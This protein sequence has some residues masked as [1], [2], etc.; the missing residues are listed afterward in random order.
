[1][2]VAYELEAGAPQPLGADCSSRGVN[3]AVYSANAERVELC[4]FAAGGTREIARLALPQRTGDIWHGFLAAPHGVAGLLYGYRVHGPYAPSLG[5]RFN[6]AKL[7]IDPCALAL[8]GDLTWHPA[9]KGAVTNQDGEPDSADSAPFIPKSRVTDT[10]FDWGRVPTPHVPWR[11]TIAYELHVKGYTQRHPGVRPELRGKYLGLAEPAVTDHLRNLGIT[12]VELMPC[13]AFVS[14]QQ[15]LQRGL[16]NFWGYNPIA[17][18]APDARYAVRDAVVEFK[19]MVR[20]LHAAGLEVVLDVVFNHT[21]E[22]DHRGPTLSWRGFDNASYY[23]LEARDRG[24]YKDF[25]GT[26]NTISFDDANVRGL[27][28]DC[29]RYWVSEMRVDGFRFDLA[30]VLG[31]DSSGFSSQSPFFAALRSDPVLAHV[32]LIAEPWDVGPGGYQLGHFPVGWSEWNDRY[33]DTVRAFWRGD[34]PLLGS[35]A[36]RL[37]GSSDLFRHHARKPTASV[38]FVAAH[39]GFT[40]HDTVAYNEKHNEAN[41]EGNQDGHSHNLSWNH[42]IEGPTDDPVIRE[43]RARQMRNMLA[44]LLLS[45]GVPMILGGDEFARTQ[46]G[47]NNAYCQD[48]DVSWV[49]WTLADLHP[50]QI[51]FVSQLC[52]LRRSRLWLRRDTFLKGSTRAGAAKDV[53]WLHPAGREMDAADWNDAGQRCIGVHLGAATVARDS[54]GH[55]V[56][57]LFNAND[58]PVEFVVPAAARELAWHVL[59]DSAHP[60]PPALETRIVPCGS[61]INVDARSVLLLE[62]HTVVVPVAPGSAPATAEGHHDGG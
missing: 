51:E 16:V 36:E 32:K 18:F 61:T 41:L 9:I 27:V 15:L 21:A 4:L 60:G 59:L 33:R 39:D 7:L 55:D 12:T 49:D 34:A 8:Q 31:R 48:N 10:R 17:W 46:R 62:A 45:Q 23:R 6:P 19:T 50:E 42:G 44:T 47:N 2:T 3:F 57:A 13:Q 28:L 58:R 20:A 29:L 54:A 30:P 14:E 1:M 25:S 43:L 5:H 38:N 56:L 40:L 53:S 52:E 35:F 24:L 22:G 11:D 37:A 26:G